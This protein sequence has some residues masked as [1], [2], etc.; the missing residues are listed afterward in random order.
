MATRGLQERAVF[1][2]QLVRCK[3]NIAFLLQHI[4]KGDRDCQVSKAAFH[5]VQNTVICFCPTFLKE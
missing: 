2:N 5:P 4:K 3:E 1:E